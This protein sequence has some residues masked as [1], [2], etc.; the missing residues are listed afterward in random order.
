MIGL[1]F[2]VLISLP[3]I[4]KIILLEKYTT[5]EEC[6]SEQ[7]RITGEMEKVYPNDTSWTLRCQVIGPRI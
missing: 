1:F 3:G 4:D 6:Q 2:I 7:V 5:L